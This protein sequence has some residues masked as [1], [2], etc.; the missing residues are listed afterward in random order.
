[1]EPLSKLEAVAED[2]NEVRRPQDYALWLENLQRFD[3]RDQA[4]VAGIQRIL[5]RLGNA[6][7]KLGQRLITD[8][9]RA[10]LGKLMGRSLPA[11]H[12]ELARLQ[13]LS[14][15]AADHDQPPD[16]VRPEMNDLLAQL[17]R[18]RPGSAEFP[19]GRGRGLAA[20]GSDCWIAKRLAP[21]NAQTAGGR[22]ANFDLQPLPPVWGSPVDLPL[23]VLYLLDVVADH[24]EPG[25]RL[26]LTAAADPGAGSAHPLEASGAGMTAAAWQNWLSPWQGYGEAREQLGP[27]LAAAII[28]QHGGTFTV[29]PLDK[30][31]VALALAIPPLVT[32]DASSKTPA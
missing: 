31:G 1:M 29:R 19:A 16:R 32:A 23:A 8:E 13:T 22:A 30:G 9:H 10:T 2:L 11:L 15:A 25:S 7:L 18:R 17:Q 4:E 21:G 14:A 5:L 6:I 20:A 26:S 27:A 24:L 12:D 28:A 3:H